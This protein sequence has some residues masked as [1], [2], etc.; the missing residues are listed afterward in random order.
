L[1]RYPEP[2]PKEL[3]HGLADLYGLPPDM[4]LATRGSDDGIDLLVRL[5][6]RAG[7]DRI[8]IC[9]PTFGMYAQTAAIQG[10]GVVC[11]ALEGNHGF[12]LNPDAIR[13]AVGAGAK[14]V[15]LCSPNNPTG[16]TIDSSQVLEL[17]RQLR[18]RAVVVLD[19]AY[20]EFSAGKSLESA[21][22]TLDNLVL[23]RTLSKAHGLAGLRC[24][25][26]LA[27]PELI[28]MLRTIMPPYPLATPVVHRVLAALQVPDV[29][30]RRQQ[31]RRIIHARER[32]ARWLSVQTWTRKVWPSA[33]NFLLVRVDDAEGML[34]WTAHGGVLLRD[35]SAQ[36][37]LENCVRV[38]IGSA[39][40]LRRFR[41]AM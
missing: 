26:V 38:S 20:V 15:F 1:N 3:V 2:Q 22:P 37:G 9:P 6:C 12:R 7:R 21:L 41:A 4:V 31:V 28:S 29:E 10:A 11:A 36:P 18:G 8:V 17:C 34:A 33:A 13:L 32:L 40:E 23:L 30:R 27:A 35:V 39:L 16:N 14:L 25:A 5:F 19:E 24:G